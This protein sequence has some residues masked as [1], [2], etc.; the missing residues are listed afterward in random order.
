MMVTVRVDETSEN[1]DPSRF[2]CPGVREKSSG[3][4]LTLMDQTF[5]L[6]IIDSGAQ[7]HR[8]LL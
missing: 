2:S 5:L 7:Q 6:G 3:S 8:A 4:N 1:L